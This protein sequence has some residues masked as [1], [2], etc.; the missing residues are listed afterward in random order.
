MRPLGLLP[1][2]WR[3]RRYIAGLPRFLTYTVTFQCNARCIMCDSWKKKAHDELTPAQLDRILPGLPNMDAVRLTGGEPFFR[4]DFPDIAETIRAHL[5]PLLLHITSNGLLT[6]RIVRFCE[7]RNRRTP[8]FLL[9]SIDGVQDYHNRIRGLET[10]WDKVMATARALAPRQRELKLTLAA[11][12]TIVDAEGFRQYRL[13]RDAL[14]PLGIKHLAV[15]AYD[16]SA[17]Y[18]TDDEVVA[19]PASAS[20][21]KTF[22]T[23]SNQELSAWLEDAR[24]DLRHGSWTD[25]L[26]KEY[27]FAGVGNRLLHG[28]GVPHPICVAMNAHMRLFPNGDIPTCQFNTV[29]AG[30]IKE[31]PFERLWFG[32]RAARQR[33]WVRQCPGCWA[34]CEV[35]PNALYS[36]DL[37]CSVFQRPALQ[38]TTDER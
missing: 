4:K 26:I 18:H 12:Q 16:V 33:E 34:E 23:F 9:L 6:D 38:P 11:N 36:G 31:Q 15:M 21:F 10:A 1:C 19:R 32:E 13:L 28:L 14:A 3:N 8:L 5:R 22:G 20:E 25:R 30:N 24:N 2:I 37:I 29:K 35:L 27:Y 7:Q 17:T